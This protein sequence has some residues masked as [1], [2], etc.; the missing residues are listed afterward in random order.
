MS[1]VPPTRVLLPFDRHKGK[2][3]VPCDCVQSDQRCMLASTALGPGFV[4]GREGELI[5][6]AALTA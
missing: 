5:P 2:V 1:P 3:G 4:L 6:N